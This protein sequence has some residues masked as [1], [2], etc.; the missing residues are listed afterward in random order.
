MTTF[1]SFTSTVRAYINGELKIPPDAKF[2]FGCVRGHVIRNDNL[3]PKEVTWSYK[4]LT[5][6]E[7]QLPPVDNSTG[8]L[9]KSVDN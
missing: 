5:E 9:S 8:R 3:I 7:L 1:I 6:E 4:N 2:A